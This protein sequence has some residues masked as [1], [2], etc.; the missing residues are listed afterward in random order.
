MNGTLF[1]WIAVFWLGLAGCAQAPARPPAPPPAPEKAR[2][3]EPEPAEGSLWTGRQ[4]YGLFA[5][6]KARNVGDIVT[7]SIVEAASA[8]KNAA[9]STGRKSDIEATWSGVLEKLTGGWV[10]GDQ[11]VGFSNQ[12]DGRGET[13]R[14]STLNADITAQVV[15]LLPNGNLVI[16][17]S[18]H[19]KVNNETQFIHI[20]GVIRPEDIL[21]S[22]IVLSTV[23]A[24]ARI[25]MGGQGALSDKQQAG[26]LSRALDWA[27][28]F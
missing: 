21:A 11:K 13:T 17:G 8:S 27:W 2:A 4:P 23:I 6:V 5:D 3:P 10:G 14:S 26:W 22:N 20:Q 7:I 1:L 9:T 16:R 18:R 12:F 15:H 28:P 24:D 19:V 25:E